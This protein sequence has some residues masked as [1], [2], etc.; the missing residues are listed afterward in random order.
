[1]TVQD[2][3]TVLLNDIRDCLARFEEDGPR[4]FTSR[5]RA[6]VL[7]NRCIT[8]KCNIES[9][10]TSTSW[11]TDQATILR[12]TEDL[13]YSL[14][15]LEQASPQHLEEDVRGDSSI[16][17]ERTK[18]HVLDVVDVVDVLDDPDAYSWNLAMKLS[19]VAAR[20]FHEILQEYFTIINHL[21]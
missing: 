4:L 14:E 15:A 7:L 17:L 9:C 10:F 3:M 20:Q 12:L 8:I 21:P 5:Q 16:L 13:V 18:A 11:M 2:H 1:M 6:N 19:I